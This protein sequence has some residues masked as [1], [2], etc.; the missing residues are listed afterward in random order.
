MNGCLKSCRHDARPR[1]PNG[2]WGRASSKMYMMNENWERVNWESCSRL[3][4]IVEGSWATAH[5]YSA[6]AREARLIQLELEESRG[7][8]GRKCSELERIERM[9]DR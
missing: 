2:R 9:C 4:I 5:H 1:N 8:R 7:E 3:M 6:W